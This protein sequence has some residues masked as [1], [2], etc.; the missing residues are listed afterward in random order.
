MKFK[1][2]TLKKVREK[3]KKANFYFK[4]DLFFI[5]NLHIST[6]LELI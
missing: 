4:T 1:Y 6:V 3:L 5:Q 2:E